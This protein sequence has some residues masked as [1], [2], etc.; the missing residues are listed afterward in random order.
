MKRGLSNLFLDGLKVSGYIC[1]ALL[2]LWFA[3]S[4]V[5]IVVYSWLSL[6]NPL[7]G[8]VVWFYSAALYPLLV[9][10]VP[11]GQVYSFLTYRRRQTKNEAPN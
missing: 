1:V 6:K 8:Q 4:F 2:L 10:S 5:G 11:I 7:F 3:L 9:L